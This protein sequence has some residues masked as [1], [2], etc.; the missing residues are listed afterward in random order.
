LEISV[1]MVAV[2]CWLILLA[3]SWYLPDARLLAASFCPRVAHN[4]ANM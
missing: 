4:M 3:S 2:A 1:V